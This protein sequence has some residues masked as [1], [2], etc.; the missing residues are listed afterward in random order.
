MSIRLTAHADVNKIDK[1]KHPAEELAWEVRRLFRELARAADLALAPLGI[2][3]AERALVEFLARARGS[4][5]I[6]EIARQRAVSRQHIHQTL[7]RLDPAWILR[8][9]DPADARAVSI[10]L[11]PEGRA[12]W[13]RIRAIDN[14]LLQ[15]L[16]G[17]V[18]LRRLKSATVALRQLRSALQERST[19]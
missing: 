15:R 13:K 7:A 8:D 17:A 14:E 18:D 4:T 6:S 19:P 10:A 1:M 3:S 9:A 12:L 5:S 2:T 16:E 11:S